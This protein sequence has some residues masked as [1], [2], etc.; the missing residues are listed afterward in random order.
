[1]ARPY[2]NR[3]RANCGGNTLGA[4]S[5][6]GFRGRWTNRQ[7]QGSVSV[8]RTF[9]LG[10]GTVAPIPD[11]RSQLVPRI[12]GSLAKTVR[13]N[14]RRCRRS[15]PRA[16][17]PLDRR[18]MRPVSWPLGLG[19]EKPRHFT[20]TTSRPSTGSRTWLKGFPSPSARR[21]LGLAVGGVIWARF[22]ESSGKWKSFRRRNSRS[23]GI[24]SP[25]LTP[26]PGIAGSRPMPPPGELDALADKAL[27][28]HAKGETTEL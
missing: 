9:E 20:S 15:S 5:Q 10:I 26:R 13:S 24:G 4:G 14:E 8:F 16:W 22:R 21:M 27:G 28:A 12:F 1:M 2:P 11:Y 18:G 19:S 25:R 23:S 17:T 3:P 7:S 6:S